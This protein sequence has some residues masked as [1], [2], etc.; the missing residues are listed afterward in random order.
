[1]GDYLL[2]ANEIHVWCW[3]R[4]ASRQRLLDVLGGYLGRPLADSDLAYR[5][6]GKP[7]IP[8][9]LLEFSLSHSAS[10][11]ALAVSAAPVGLD[12]EH[13]IDL[14]DL[15]DVAAYALG[16]LER[17]ALADCATAD[18]NRFFHRCWTRKEAYLKGVGCGLSLAPHLADTLHVRDWHLHEISIAGCA[19]CVA[20]RIEGARMVFPQAS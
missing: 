19:G 11:T 10:W 13:V 17:D 2:P 18:R 16:P 6:L 15:D 3:S 5:P 9:S 1:M 4:A 14:P 8:G 7:F 20:T 12:I